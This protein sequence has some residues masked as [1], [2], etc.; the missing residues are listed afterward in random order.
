MVSL[1]ARSEQGGAVDALGHGLVDER[2][3]MFTE[4]KVTEIFCIADDFC[5]LY[6]AMMAKYTVKSPNKRPY[7][8]DGTLSKA[9]VMLIMI[10]FHGS[11]Y[12][13]L[14]H[15]Y[16]EHVSKHLRG[17]CSARVIMSVRN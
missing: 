16:L 1:C 6:D 9:E 8:R 10:L 2:S 15:F 11:G 5:K 7:H 12:R 13:C 4:N 14:K 17:H 3:L